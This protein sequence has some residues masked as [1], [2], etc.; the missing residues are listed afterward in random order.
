MFFPELRCPLFSM[1]L[2]SMKPSVD[3]LPRGPSMRFEG[4]GCEVEGGNKVASLAFL[5]FSLP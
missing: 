4:D 2:G 1:L 5:L 3:N